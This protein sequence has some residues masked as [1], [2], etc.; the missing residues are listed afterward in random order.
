MVTMTSESEKKVAIVP[1]KSI[2]TAA[3]HSGENTPNILVYKKVKIKSKLLFMFKILRF[4]QCYPSIIL[5][6]IL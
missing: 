2:N 4:I 5:R 1:K 6:K 3:A